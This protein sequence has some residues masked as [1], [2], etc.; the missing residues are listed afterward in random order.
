MIDLSVS[1]LIERFT[2]VVEMST[3]LSLFIEE[4]ITSP[5]HL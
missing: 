2:E 5:L 1:H 4:C 3:Y